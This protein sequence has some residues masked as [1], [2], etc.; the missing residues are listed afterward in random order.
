MP[1][2]TRVVVTSDFLGV[3]FGVATLDVN[4]KIPYAQIPD[5]ILGS[6]PGVVTS[7]DGGAAI[8]MY[9]PVQLIDGGHASTTYTPTQYIDG[10]GASA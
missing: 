2:M 1:T 4:G 9:M 10:G 3:P 6:I 8:S 5:T 7:I